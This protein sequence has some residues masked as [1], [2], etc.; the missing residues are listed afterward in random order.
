MHDWFFRLNTL[1]FRQKLTKF[2]A[3]CRNM[4]FPYG[5]YFL[6]ARFLFF[7]FLRQN[8]FILFL[9][10]IYLFNYALLFFQKS[11]KLAINY[12]NMNFSRG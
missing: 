7:F 5:R 2:A 1:L 10:F 11:A 4:N 12:Q 9:L 6:N 3:K 8:L